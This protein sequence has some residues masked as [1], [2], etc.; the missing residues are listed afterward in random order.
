MHYPAIVY[1]RNTINSRYAD[2][3]PYMHKHRY[4]V[5][6]IDSDPDSIIPDLVADLPMC[7]HNRRFV[8]DNLYHD[9][10]DLYY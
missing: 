7:R 6:V 2:N 5:T 8:S 4:E 9:A 1:Q 3:E 10:F